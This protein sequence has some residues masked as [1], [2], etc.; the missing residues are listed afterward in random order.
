MIQ[1]KNSTHVHRY[2]VSTLAIVI[3]VAAVSGMLIW[4]RTR[5]DAVSRSK[6]TST[7]PVVSMFSFMGV[8]GWWRGA[9]NRTSMALFDTDTTDGCFVSDQYQTGTVDV[10]AELQSNQNTLIAGGYSIASAGTQESTLQANA[11]PVQYQLAQYSVTSSPTASQVMGGQ[12][13]GYVQLTGG[14]I[15][16]MG[17]CNAADELST[18][19]P[20][21]QAITFAQ[22]D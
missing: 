18:T 9:T 5:T 16:I 21:L 4:N 19:I 12:E 6:R 14:Y 15:K 8:S 10:A 11:S 20:A 13:F 22:T 1:N 7:A 3:V 17:Y 2:V